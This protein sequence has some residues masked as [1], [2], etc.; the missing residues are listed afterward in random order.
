LMILNLAGGLGLFL[1]GMKTMSDGIRKTAGERFH[2]LLNAVT[3]TPVSAI[4]TGLLTTALIQSSSATTVMLVSLVNA[5]LVG[6]SQAIGVIMGANIGTTLTSWIVSFFGFSVKISVVALP[7]IAVSLPL[8]FS[9][10]DRLRDISAILFGFGLLFLG[11]YEMKEAVGSVQES[12]AA[13]QFLRHL[14]G[15]GFFS[16]LLFVIIGTLLTIAVQSSSAAMTITLTL[17]FNGWIPF[18]VAAAIVLGENVGTT[19][20]AYLASLEMNIA[21]KR[22]ARAHM[23]FNL[24][25]VGWVLILFRPLLHLVDL[26]VPGSSMTAETLPYHLSAFHTLFNLMNTVLLV[27]F[28][29]IIEKLVVRLVPEPVEPGEAG[30][31]R[32][33]QVNLVVVDQAEINLINGRAEVGRMSRVVN[34]MMLDLLNGIG[35]DA[36][37][38]VPIEENLRKDEELVDVMQVELSSFLAECSMKSLS[39]S[40]AYEVRRLL[41]IVNELES[42]SDACHK[43]VVLYLRKRTKGLSFHKNASAEISDYAMKVADFLRYNAD[44]LNNRLASQEFT[45]AAE[46]E[47]GINDQRKALTRLSRKNIEKGGNL[48]GELLYM[49]IIRHM[50]HIGDF[51]LNISQAIHVA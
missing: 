5:Q 26:L 31:Y 18:D 15:F 8:H 32:I 48:R 19:I 24:I 7:A 10:R 47:E 40:Q 4:V 6:L 21:A 43:I 39:E 20:T 17:A 28:I 11:L 16:L 50:E 37:E 35:A 29:P 41:R 33:P 1:F 2:R 36:K 27:W 9:K 22:A 13:L 51:C 3:G 44:F 49:E 12:A 34:G 25:G 23:V 30:P 45:I 42:I 38:L 14:T 46:M